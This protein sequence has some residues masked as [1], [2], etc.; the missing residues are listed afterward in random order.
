MKTPI[1]LVQ[2]RPVYSGSQKASTKLIIDSTKRP[3]HHHY[4][5]ISSRYICSKNMGHKK[6][7][8]NEL[9]HWRLGYIG[10]SFVHPRRCTNV[11][12]LQEV[13]LGTRVITR[14]N[15]NILFPTSVASCGD[16]SDCERVRRM[17]LWTK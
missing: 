1:R 17:R 11:S 10:S 7:T 15:R 13:I 12:G 3:T 16:F 14:M 4:S 2:T 8:Q 6:K 5:A 9:S